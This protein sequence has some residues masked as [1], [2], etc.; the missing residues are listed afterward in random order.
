M[1]AM[2]AGV[3]QHAITALSWLGTIAV[4]GNTVSK[5]ITLEGVV[6][7]HT[8]STLEGWLW[9]TVILVAG[10]ALGWLVEKVL[11]FQLRK[12][13]HDSSLPFIPLAFDAMKGMPLLWITLFSLDAAILSLTL[14]PVVTG[15]LQQIV[16]IVFLFSGVIIF[17]RLF[18]KL[19]EFALNHYGKALPSTSIFT[20]ITRIS[21]YALGL[22]VILQTAG[23]SIT[24][25][26]TAL[27]IGGLA[28]SLA[29]QDTLAN[30]FS[31]VHILVSRQIVPGHFIELNSGEKGY[32]RDI[33]WR[34]TT[35][36]SIYNYLYIIPNS[37]V[38]SAVVTN[39][40]YPKKKV[41]AVFKMG[42]SYES[43]L[44][45]V[46]AVTLDVA[47]KTLERLGFPVK[48]PPWLRYTTFNDFSI[49]FNLMFE[50][51][52]YTD[53]FPI[54]HELVKALHARYR[55]EGI[56]IPYPI[57]TLD[58]P[59]GHLHELAQARSSQL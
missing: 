24:P 23:I 6:N 7:P 39:Y 19:V 43:D 25:L 31:G 16:T 46:E 41:T 37:K 1:H 13:L 20:I 56:N 8:V 18:C 53:F 22:M 34:N 14:R 38:A 44:E 32:V 40:Y 47:Q 27:G 29:F 55:Q 3:P 36:E 58:I 33:N 30:L 11:F 28:I 21:V 42:V 59:A 48:N 52:E 54:R 57:R 10:V 26:I 49:D 9:P 12:L 35:I 4:T 5:P 45:H 50:V 15:Y 51:P 17:A 2:F